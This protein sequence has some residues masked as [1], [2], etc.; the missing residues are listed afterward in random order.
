M[1]YAIIAAGEGSRLRDEGILLPKPLVPLAGKA[2]VDRLM[3][4]MLHCGAES[5]SVICNSQMPEVHQ[6][7]LA[8]R[9]SHP[10]LAM[11]LI[12]ETTPS[13]MHSLA[14]LSAVIPEGKVCVTTVDTIFHE[15][16]FA[17]YIQAFEQCQGGLFA[18][19]PF[20]DDER[21]LW[22]ACSKEAGTTFG[23][24][25]CPL[26][27]G[28]F[29]D[30]AQMAD[31]VWHFVSG[32]IYGLETSTAWPVLH[33]C[34]AEGQSR[35]RNF[36]RALVRANV[37]L[38]AY[39][40]GKVM[41]IDHASDLRKAEAWLDESLKTR[42]ILAVHRAPEFSPNLAVSDAA[43]LQLVAAKLEEEGCRVDEV[44]EDTFDRMSD[45]EL[46]SYELV[47]H[48]MRRM[49][50][51]L[52]LQRLGLAAVNAPQAVLTVAKSREM[53]LELLQQAGIAVPQWWAYEAS[54]DQMFQCE[55]ELQQLLP[56]WV[57]VMREGGTRHDDVTWVETPLEADTR[58]MELVA[59]RVPDIVVTRHIEGDLLKVY[60]VMPDF[61][62]AFYP[63]EMNYTKFGTAEQHNTALAHIKYREED[64]RAIAWGIART[65]GIEIFGF[66]VIVEPDGHIVVIDVNDWPSFSAY[67]Q[68][69]ASAIAALIIDSLDKIE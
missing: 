34:L 31:D 13:S 66:D 45:D 51:L 3:D 40:F 9:D 29:D 64:L 39:V 15:R 52:K 18:V 19:T 28:F 60:A 54:E 37:P 67:R 21:P 48:M 61:V 22:V 7:L 47:V 56:G 8:Y 5:I 24:R 27:H 10:D 32:G 59:Q 20:V 41:D 68:K 63:Q 38:S 55:P 11:N 50:S 6:H 69:G 23:G 46:R 2:M 30:E 33:Q 25:V 62:Y 49:S 53:T 65:F 17:A 12:V 58:V 16:E 44:D 14:R 36:Q 4:V 43:I 35:M 42:S 26:I 1:H 57:K